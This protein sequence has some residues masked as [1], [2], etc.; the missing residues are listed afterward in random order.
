MTPKPNMTAE[1]I[2]KE[3]V[4][5]EGSKSGNIFFNF[6]IVKV[7][8]KA[9]TAFGDRR[10]QEGKKE[11]TECCFDAHSQCVEKKFQL[12][13]ARREALKQAAQV[14]EAQK[15]FDDAG[16]IR[17]LVG[18]AGEETLYSG[19]CRHQVPFGSPCKGCNR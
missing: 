8:E 6:H 3:I 16:M 14:S 5:F 15:H 1:E 4:A 19:Q 12:D 13:K 11:A 7:I 2:A 18:E 10:W 9:L 17:A